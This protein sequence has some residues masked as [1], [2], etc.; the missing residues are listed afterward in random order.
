M[1]KINKCPEFD[2]FTVPEVLNLS[3]IPALDG[4]R[5]FA[6]LTVLFGH[7]LLNTSWALLALANVGVEIF[8]VLSGFLITSLILKEKLKNGRVSLKRFYIRR[9]LRILPVAYLFLIILLVLNYLFNLN[10][11]T[12]SFVASA[13]YVK[14]FHLNYA[15]NWFNGHFWTLAIE[16]QFYVVFPV[17][18]V[19]S[20]KSYIRLIFIIILSVPLLQSLGFHNVGIFYSNY[21]VHKITFL[22]INLFENGTPSILI[23]SYL[24]ILM[25]R[26]NIPTVKTKTNN[27]FSSFLLLNAM[28]FRVTC[29]KFIHNDYINSIIFSLIIALV[30][31]LILI[32][33]EDF[34]GMILKNKYSVRLGILSYS[35]YIWQQ[36][37]LY[38][39]PWENTFKYSNS[40]FLNLPVLFII[41]YLSYNFFELRFL[42]LKER[43]K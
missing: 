11:S 32:N 34:L 30:I 29:T 19:Y 7:M 17:I 39:Q 41:S 36:I 40:L 3:Y 15:S 20:L 25:F 2:K 38:K 1:L 18:L 35:I 14:N 13:L 4:L 27:Y 5:G 37:F 8:F 22:L 9:V 24:S 28:I 16:E 33:S 21:L 43:F 6:I 31:Y 23:G 10:L 42:K 26:K 12:R